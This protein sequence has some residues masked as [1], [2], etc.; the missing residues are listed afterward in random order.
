MCICLRVAPILTLLS[1]QNWSRAG[2]ETMSK[3]VLLVVEASMSHTKL[4]SSMTSISKYSGYEI[5]SKSKSWPAGWPPIAFFSCSVLVLLPLIVAYLVC[6]LRVNREMLSKDCWGGWYFLLRRLSYFC[7]P[8]PFFIVLETYLL[9]NTDVQKV[10][11]I[12]SALWTCYCVLS[13]FVW[14]NICCHTEDMEQYTDLCD[15]MQFS[16]T[17]GIE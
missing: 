10:R 12:Q 11:A 1:I 8:D 17:R 4:C 7:D 15:K 3:A 13:K 14:N 6:I 5:L 16:T 9:N 2:E